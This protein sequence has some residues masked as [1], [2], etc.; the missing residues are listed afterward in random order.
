MVKINANPVTPII[1]IKPLKLVPSAAELD[2]MSVLQWRE[3]LHMA[4]WEMRQALNRFYYG[5]P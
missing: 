3:E 1:T 5:A 2:G 4:R